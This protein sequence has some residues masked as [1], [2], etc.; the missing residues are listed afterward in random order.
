MKTSLPG[1]DSTPESWEIDFINQKFNFK[2]NKK[3]EKLYRY[4]SIF[5]ESILLLSI[6]VLLS[7]V[8]ISSMFFMTFILFFIGIFTI[9]FYVFSSKYR[10]WFR[11][12]FAWGLVKKK[13]IKKFK[14]LSSNIKNKNLKIYFKNYY[15]DCIRYNDFVDYLEKVNCYQIFSSEVWCA[16]F[17]FKDNPKSG[18]MLLKY[19]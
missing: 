12:K 11:N 19:Y 15:L 5:I 18:Y 7:T 14:I 17:I 6:F 3:Y 2:S 16:E 4:F 9:F 10:Y 8:F 13:E 1:I